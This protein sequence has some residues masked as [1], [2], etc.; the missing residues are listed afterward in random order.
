VTLRWR[1]ALILAALA[2][3]VGAFAAIASYVRTESQL[4]SSIDDTLR[5]AAAAVP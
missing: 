5:G 4:R 1:I 3:A 2:L